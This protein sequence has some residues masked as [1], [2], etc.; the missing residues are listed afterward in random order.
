MV[1]LKQLTIEIPSLLGLHAFN[2]LTSAPLKV[3]VVG[4]ASREDVKGK[5]IAVD[6][7]KIDQSYASQGANFAEGHL[8]AATGEAIMEE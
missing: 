7:T 1:L 3:V 6:L 4:E 2:W 8:H 5:I